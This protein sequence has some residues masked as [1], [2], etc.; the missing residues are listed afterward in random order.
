MEVLVAALLLG[1][2]LGCTGWWLAPRQPLSID[3]A[4]FLVVLRRLRRG[5][6]LYQ[7]VFF[8]AGPVPVWLAGS[9]TKRFGERLLTLRRLTVLYATATAVILGLFT[10]S[11]GVPWGLAM[12][13]CAG[14]ALVGDLIWSVDN[15]YGMLSR[16]GAALALLAAVQLSAGA[17]LTT[18]WIVTG[19]GGVAL[20]LLSKYTLGLTASVAA[21]A[22]LVFRNPDQPWHQATGMLGVALL[23]TGAALLKLIR[24]GI[25]KAAWV[26]LV[27]NKRSFIATAG[28]SFLRR[29]RDLRNPAPGG[30][31]PE[32]WRV[33]GWC[34]PLLVLSLLF[35]AAGTAR[36]LVAGGPARPT[37]AVL[38]MTAVGL[39]G[40]WPRA[41]EVHVRTGIG[42]VLAAGLG[43]GRLLFPGATWGLAALAALAGLAALVISVRTPGPAGEPLG[44]PT[45]GVRTDPWDPAA[46]RRVGAE[47]AEVTGPRVFLLRADAALMYLVTDLRNPTP[48]DYPLASVFGPHGQC[49]VIAALASGRIRYCCW[50]PILGG[51]LT[52]TELEATVAALPV[53]ATGEFGT[54]VSAR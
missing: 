23:L 32:L 34:F 22:I 18:C 10:H 28:T 35:V 41:D 40:L 27:R 33:S 49:E 30:I 6:R 4:W 13:G 36:V 48:Y 39:S 16:L 45:D 5:R 47:L 50:A 43:G 37:A 21:L 11:V 2:A 7:Q 20:A 12:L 14:G 31:S 26:R 15:H 46:V 54:V 42:P 53:V 38:A 24:D 44:L 1:A 25:G 9:W 17:S 29:W 19:G 52:P 3:E 8:G 51:P